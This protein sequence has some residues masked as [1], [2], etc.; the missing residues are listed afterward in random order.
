MSDS[1]NLIDSISSL[2]STRIITLILAFCAT[3]P[4]G[5]MF[6][7]LNRPDLFKELD[8]YRLTTIS[9]QITVP[10]FMF[11]ALMCGALIK[12][13]ERRQV[14]PTETIE[15]IGILNMALGLSSAIVLTAFFTD[16]YFLS[17]DGFE[18]RTHFILIFC[19]TGIFY[20]FLSW[21]IHL[22]SKPQKGK[23]QQG[24]KAS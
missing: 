11:V 6:L 21:L 18:I 12:N 22:D 14:I 7:F 19:F 13:Y 15:K 4:N 24:K 23:K 9:I 17:A 1:K 10:L 16:F 2:G 3:I 8:I 20:A 5:F